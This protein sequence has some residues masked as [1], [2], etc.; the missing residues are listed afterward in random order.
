MKNEVKNKRGELTAYGY[1]CGYVSEFSLSKGGKC[2][3]YHE[4]GVYHVRYFPEVN[5]YEGR[6][7]FS[8]ESLSVARKAFRVFCNKVAADHYF[9]Q[10]NN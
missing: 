2:E 4:G 3:L 1:A 7:W 9:N 10:F 5:P 6:V 8:H